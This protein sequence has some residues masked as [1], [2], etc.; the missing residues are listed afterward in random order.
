MDRKTLEEEQTKILDNLELHD[1][2]EQTRQTYYSAHLLKK[3]KDEFDYYYERS[4]EDLSKA[5]GVNEILLKGCVV[6]VDELYPDYTEWGLYD[7]N[8][9]VI[10]VFSH[11]Y[12]GDVYDDVRKAYFELFKNI[13]N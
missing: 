11:Q 12:G 10:S 5:T 9:I 13:S 6:L 8:N 2:F 4:I 1:S 7:S 3:E